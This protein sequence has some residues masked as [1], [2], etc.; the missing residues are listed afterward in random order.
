MTDVIVIGGGIIGLTAALRLQQ[1]GAAVSVWSPV[2]P[3]QTVWSV[4][5]AVW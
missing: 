1:A 2:G 5:A 3:E 4:A